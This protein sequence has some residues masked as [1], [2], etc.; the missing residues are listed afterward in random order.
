M[1]LDD[2]ERVIRENPGLTATQIAKVLYGPHSYGERVRTAC[3]MLSMAGQI[4]RRGRG[5]PAEPFTYYPLSGGNPGQAE[6]R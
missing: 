1:L 4:E 6:E 5:G 3:L 2:V